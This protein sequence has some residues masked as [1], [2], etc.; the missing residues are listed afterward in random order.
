MSVKNKTFWEL[1]A[2]SVRKYR[3]TP[4]GKYATYK[5]NARVYNRQFSLTLK[6]FNDIISEPCFYCGGEGFGIDRIDSNKWYFQENCL[7]CCSMCNRM[8]S[9][10]NIKQFLEQCNKITKNICQ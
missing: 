7:S 4:K 2:D 9:D 8:K 10:F 6:Q 5:R 3:Q 1:N